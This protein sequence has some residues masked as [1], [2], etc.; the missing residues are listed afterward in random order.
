LVNR[1]QRNLNQ[2]KEPHL[3]YYKNAEFHYDMKITQEAGSSETVATER[4]PATQQHIPENR[5]HN[6]RHKMCCVSQSTPL[7]KSVMP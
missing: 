6:I 5:E 1:K 4:Y 3:N 7:H 2:L